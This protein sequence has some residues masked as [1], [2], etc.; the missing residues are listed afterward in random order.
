MQLFYGKRMILDRTTGLC[1]KI[2]AASALCQT[3]IIRI[4]S[5][6]QDQFS[7]PVYPVFDAH[8]H[9]ESKGVEKCPQIKKQ[10]FCSL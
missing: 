4:S 8:L 6:G 1:L 3:T 7:T 5:R 2:L 9:R 10:Q